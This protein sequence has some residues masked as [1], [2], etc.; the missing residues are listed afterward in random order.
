MTGVATG[1]WRFVT[2]SRIARSWFQY[3]DSETSYEDSV[4]ERFRIVHDRSIWLVRPSTNWLPNSR[5]T[6]STDHAGE[7]SERFLWIGIKDQ[8]AAMGRLLVSSDIPLHKPR[9]EGSAPTHTGI[10]G[11]CSHAPLLLVVLPFLVSCVLSSLWCAAPR[12]R[13]FGRL[14]GSMSRALTAAG[15]TAFVLSSN[16]SRRD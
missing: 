15:F 5:N 3:H 7:Q 6:K 4:E 2:Q 9:L 13:K 1:R 14:S 12:D 10:S 8:S 11:D 16:Q